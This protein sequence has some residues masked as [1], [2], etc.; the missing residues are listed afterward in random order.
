MR[1]D[2]QHEKLAKNVKRLSLDPPVGV[3]F[4]GF[5]LFK[6]HQYTPQPEG[7]G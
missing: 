5:L 1:S 4:G 7:A 2:W 6:N 3:F